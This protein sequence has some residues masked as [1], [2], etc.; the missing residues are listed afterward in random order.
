MAGADAD[1]GLPV[2]V[3]KTASMVAVQMR[4]DG[5]LDIRVWVDAS[6]PELRAEA[7]VRANLHGD[8][9][10]ANLPPRKVSLLQAS[11]RL[12][13]V[14]EK[15]A[16]WV[17]YEKS[18]D[19][20]GLGQLPVRQEPESAKEYISGRLCQLAGADANGARLDNLDLD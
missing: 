18:V 8:A 5:G 11:G 17:L 19:R 15:I 2:D 9:V 4:D 7:L 20:K 1:V 13:Q 6:L 3:R 10:L 16:L 14:E 12:A